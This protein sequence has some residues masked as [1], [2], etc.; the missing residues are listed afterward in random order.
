MNGGHGM[1]TKRKRKKNKFLPMACALGIFIG[2]ICNSY[3]NAY[4]EALPGL[5]P[6]VDLVSVAD[7][8]MAYFTSAGMFI[9]NQDWINELYTNFGG[10]AGFYLGDLY[11]NGLLTLDEAGHFVSSGL[12]TALESQSGWANLHLDELFRVSAEEAAVGGGVAATGAG[13]IAGAVGGVASTGLLPLAF[14]VTGA[15]WGG[16]GLGTLV[17]HAVG[18]YG[19]AIWEGQPMTDAEYI[20]NLPAGA[21]VG[22]YGT[23]INYRVVS[24]SIGKILFASSQN[25]GYMYLINDSNESKSSGYDTYDPNTGSKSHVNAFVS[26]KSSSRIS[27][28][29]VLING[30]PNAGNFVSDQAMID[31]MNGV[32][33]GVISTTNRSPDIIGDE[34]NAQASQNQS[35][36]Y[37]VPGISPKVDPNNQSVKPGNVTET[38]YS[39]WANGVKQNNNDG[40]PDANA[41]ILQ[42]ILE[43]IRTASPSPGGNPNPNPNPN[44]D[45]SPTP[46]PKP[47]YD[48]S[49]PDQP[50]YDPKE[51]ENPDDITNGDPWTTPDLLDRFPFCLPRDVFR[52]FEKLDV[53]ERMAPSIS[54]HFVTPLGI[55]FDFD[56]DLR[57][58][59]GVAT[60]LR[61]LELIAFVIGLALATRNLIGR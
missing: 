13:T 48:P 28:G 46:V 22:S 29:S 20:N 51:T 16:I 54:W 8:M 31:Y 59:E 10:G 32:A 61:T 2:S 40:D 5:P 43:A 34:G 44:P 18:L 42:E 49:Q 60:I 26:A 50:E 9:S 41:D 4:A 23:G 19:R 17:A 15:Y 56:L 12:D 11:Q 1:N 52:C 37:T 55:H 45:P 36:G 58:Y 47:D 27:R 7:C 39:R 33:T 35:G 6:G 14:G 30:M 3:M 57:D 25:Q 38:D 53:N 24:S 21:S